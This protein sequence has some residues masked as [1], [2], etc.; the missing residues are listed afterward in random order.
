MCQVR[1][2]RLFA[3][4]R[5]EASGLNAGDGTYL[6]VIGGVTRDADRA[7]HVAIL[8]SDQDAGRAGHQPPVTHSGKRGEIES[9]TEEVSP[10]AYGGKLGRHCTENPTALL[11]TVSEEILAESEH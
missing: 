8:V 7:D 11:V 5:R 3:G 1:S 10:H 9:E 6:V 4:I 2:G